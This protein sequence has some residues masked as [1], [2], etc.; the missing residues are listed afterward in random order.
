MGASPLPEQAANKLREKL[1]R[2]KIFRGKS[3]EKTHGIGKILHFPG[4]DQTYH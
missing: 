2:L 4:M 1:L 3:N